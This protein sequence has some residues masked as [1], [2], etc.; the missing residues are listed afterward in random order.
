MTHQD[1]EK[2]RDGV[3]V[4]SL[5]LSSLLFQGKAG[6]GTLNALLLWRLRLGLAS[7]AR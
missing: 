2:A 1:D 5:L 6:L 4:G 7:Q 3:G